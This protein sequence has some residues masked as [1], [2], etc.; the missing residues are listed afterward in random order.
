MTANVPTLFLCRTQPLLIRLSL[1]S[2]LLS[3]CVG[4]CQLWL[5][6]AKHCH[7]VLVYLNNQEKQ[8]LIERPALPACVG[9]WI[10]VLTWGFL[11]ILTSVMSLINKFHL[12]DAIL[13][14]KVQ[15]FSF[16]VINVNLTWISHTPC[17]VW[18]WFGMKYNEFK[19]INLNINQ[20]V[21][22]LST[23]FCEFLS[24]LQHE[25]FKLWKRLKAS[26][27]LI[28]FYHWLFW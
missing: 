4:L 16:G 2:F 27:V 23:C 20:T 18:I 15:N 3:V 12:L 1:F 22:F 26:P 6:F 9:F 5:H 24:S 21:T 28:K 10:L 13:L 8:T 25:T 17:W 11:T 19:C 7:L 14:F